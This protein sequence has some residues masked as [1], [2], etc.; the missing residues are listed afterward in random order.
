LDD[1][2]IW[3]LAQPGPDPGGGAAAAHGGLLG[4]AVLEK[5]IRLELN[6]KTRELFWTQVLEE[7][8]K[9]MHLMDSLKTLDVKAYAD[10][11]KVT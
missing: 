5:I 2:F 8:T 4:L 6:R 9:I 7:H 10:L 3:R 1:T 11:V